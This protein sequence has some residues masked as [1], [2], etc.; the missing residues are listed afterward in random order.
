[1]VSEEKG[2][3]NSKS[4]APNFKQ[5]SNP[6]DRNLK[7]PLGAFEFSAWNLFEI[8]DLRFCYRY[9]VSRGIRQLWLENNPIP[10]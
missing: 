6:K 8:W 7:T 5:V 9:D 1:M 4:E 2:V 3:E 10:C